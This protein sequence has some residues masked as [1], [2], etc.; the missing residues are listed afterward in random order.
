MLR[1][2]FFFTKMSNSLKSSLN[3]FAGSPNLASQIKLQKL[4]KAGLTLQNKAGF[5]FKSV[6]HTMANMGIFRWS[7]ITVLPFV[8]LAII[9][10]QVAVT[11]STEVCTKLL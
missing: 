5:S 2:H 6:F 7:L 3:Y 10:S 1:N 4:E 8:V 11:Y 9:S